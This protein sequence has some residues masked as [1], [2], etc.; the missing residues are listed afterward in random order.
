MKNALLILVLCLLITVSCEKEVNPYQIGAQHVGLLTDSTQ[1]KDLKTIF[2]NDSVVR[3]EEDDGFTGN[4][5]DIQ[6]YSKTGEPLLIVSPTEANDSTALI[7]TVRI[8][9]SRYQTEK[10]ISSLSTFKA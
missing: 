10:G 1:V 2:V 6:I 9:D 3:F 8:M 7:N 5:N 4:I